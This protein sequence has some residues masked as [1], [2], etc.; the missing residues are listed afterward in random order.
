M[1]PNLHRKQQLDCRNNPN[2]LRW[3]IALRYPMFVDV[4]TG[5][6]THD[7]VI[8]HAAEGRTWFVMPMW[9]NFR[10]CATID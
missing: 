6:D 4:D 9:I 10:I 2:V 7:T 8:L 3:K 1:P 5:I